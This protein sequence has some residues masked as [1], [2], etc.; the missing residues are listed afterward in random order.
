MDESIKLR[1]ELMPRLVKGF[2]FVTTVLLALTTAGN[3][4][5]Q[6]PE[7][8]LD[9]IYFNV[10]NYYPD[11]LIFQVRLNTDNTGN[12]RLAGFGVPLTIT[13]TPGTGLVLLDTTLARTF[14]GSVASGFAILA[15][16]TD[17]T[18]GPGGNNPAVSPVKYVFGGATFTGG[19]FSPDTNLLLA[20]IKLN[21]NVTAVLIT[22]DTTHTNTALATSLVTIFGAEY[23]PAWYPDSFD[24]LASDV[25]DIGGSE[26]SNRPLVFD[27]K[28]NYPNP[29]NATTQIQ[30]A[31]PQAANVKLEIFNVLGQKVRTLVDEELQAGYKQVA[32]DGTDEVG[33]SVA[34]GIYFYRLRA[35]GLFTEMK[36]MLLVK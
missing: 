31:L 30:F 24:Y 17:S 8:T 19:Y 12:N 6:D 16:N 14:A 32:W 29:F 4:S 36:K 3:V 7:G 1:R 22:I 11:S 18:G 35:E 33:K 5:A 2:L 9:S 28:Q 27:L 23:S 25:K 21:I 26:P 13:V 34:T 15:T 10:I 20:T